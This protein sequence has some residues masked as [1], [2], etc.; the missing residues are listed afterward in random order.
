MQLGIDFDGTV[1]RYYACYKYGQC[2]TMCCDACETLEGAKQTIDGLK[3]R[4]T[5]KGRDDVKFWI[6]KQTLKAEKVWPEPNGFDEFDDEFYDKYEDKELVAEQEK[7]MKKRRGRLKRCR[8]ES[9][10]D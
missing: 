1:I 9:I 8:N 4:K 10:Q 5:I 3:R 7:E 2:S 6:M